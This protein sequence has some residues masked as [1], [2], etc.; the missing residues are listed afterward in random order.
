VEEALGQVFGLLVVATLAAQVAV[1]WLPVLPE[2]GTNQ[3]VIL[4]AA[5]LDALDQRPLGRQKR[6]PRPP[7]IGVVAS[8]HRINLTQWSQHA[9]LT[10]SLNSIVALIRRQSTVYGRF[11]SQRWAWFS[12]AR[13][14]GNTFATRDVHVLCRKPFRNKMLRTTVS[15]AGQRKVLP[16]FEPGPKMPTQAPY[17]ARLAQRRAPFLGVSG[18]KLFTGAR[19]EKPATTCN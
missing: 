9:N 11:T 6:I 1:D 13:S 3:R 18:R 19:I 7:H 16:C 14:Q 2:Q 12:L 10:G 17:S 8:A 5:G 4:A 15:A